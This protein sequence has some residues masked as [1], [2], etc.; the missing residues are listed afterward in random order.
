MKKL[1]AQKELEAQLR[2]LKE[3]LERS[4]NPYDRVH[5][6]DDKWYFYDEDWERVEPFPYEWSDTKCAVVGGLASFYNHN[7]VNP[8]VDYHLNKRTK[9]YIFTCIVPISKGDEL[10][11]DYCVDVDFEIK[12]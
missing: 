6:H 5:T 12:K 1:E 11:F 4:N 10:T 9:E 3:K 2:A 7:P 8:N